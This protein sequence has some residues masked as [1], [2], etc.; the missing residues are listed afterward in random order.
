VQSSR[1][2]SREPPAQPI[3]SVTQGSLSS[4]DERARAVAAALQRARARRVTTG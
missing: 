3:S 4:Q 1:V 2:E